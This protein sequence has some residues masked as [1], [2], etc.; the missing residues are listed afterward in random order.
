VHKFR[1]ISDVIQKEKDFESIRRLSEAQ[2]VMEKFVELFPELRAFAAP[3]RFEKG[4]LNLKVENSVWRSELKFNQATLIE[5]LNKHFKENIVK[6][7]R[8]VS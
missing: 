6:T 5:K 2:D 4:T 8:F 1:R 3:V 7:I